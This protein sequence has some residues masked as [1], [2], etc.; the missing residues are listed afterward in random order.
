[1]RIEG[2][3]RSSCAKDETRRCTATRQYRCATLAITF[4]V[5]T[6]GYDVRAEDV[7]HGPRRD[8]RGRRGGSVEAEGQGSLNLKLEALSNQ[9]WSAMRRKDWFSGCSGMVALVRSIILV[10]WYFS[11]WWP[12]L[13][14]QYARGW[15]NYCICPSGTCLAITIAPQII[16][17]HDSHH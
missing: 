11:G 4:G 15:S 14:T 13:I 10:I 16:R 17:S 3:G 7:G 5:C 6:R 1:M 9:F 2:A 12:Q 8:G